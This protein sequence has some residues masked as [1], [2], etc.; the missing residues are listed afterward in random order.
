MGQ[1]AHLLGSWHCRRWL[2]LCAT[3]PPQQPDFP[4]HDGPEG[5]ARTPRPA[6]DWISGQ[7]GRWTAGGLESLTCDGSGRVQQLFL[8]NTNYY[9]CCDINGDV[10]TNFSLT[11]PLP[12]ALGQ[13]SALQALFVIDDGLT[14]TIPEALCSLSSLQSLSLL[15]SSLVFPGALVR[16]YLSGTIPACLG[17]LASLSYLCAHP[18]LDSDAPRPP[19]LSL[20]R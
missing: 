14:G 4:R 10:A 1:P 3:A 18:D 11:A 15:S 6:G 9:Y 20:P 8:E 19:T 16:N 2:V 5:P 12:A 13:L 17:S 7:Y